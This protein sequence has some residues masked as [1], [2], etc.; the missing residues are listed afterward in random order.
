M[1]KLKKISDYPFLIF[2]LF[3]VIAYFP[4][5]LPSFHLKNDLVTQNLP[6]R[7]FISESLY[8]N[9]FPWWNPFIHF[10]IPQYGDMNNGF[11]NPIMWLFAK[12]C[13]YDIWAI[14]YEEMLYILLGRLAIYKAL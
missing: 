13:G 4:V 2:L 9:Y 6:T 3:V 12:F 5:L 14:T 8:S 1:N 7:Y 10:G 11:W